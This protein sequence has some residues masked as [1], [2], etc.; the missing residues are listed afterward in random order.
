M[1]PKSLIL[2]ALALGCGLV[3]S[4]GISQVMDRRADG[5]Q[6]VVETVPIFVAKA[7]IKEMTLLT[8]QNVEQEQWPKA[9]VPA[10]ALLKHE[11]WEGQ[12]P[13]V[14]IYKGEPIIK[15]KI[16]DKNARA[17]SNIPNGFRTVAISVD[18]VSNLGG[19]LKPHDKVDVLAYFSRN[20][21]N[22]I[23]ETAVR[24]ILR[25]VEVFAVDSQYKR[26]D[27]G[28]EVTAAKVVSL[29]V[30]PDQ[31]EKITLA[32]ETGKIRL[33]LRNNDDDTNVESSGE[34]RFSDLGKNED[35]S[36]TPDQP[37]KSTASDAI[38][39]ILEVLSTP[40]KAE[41]P[42]PEKV[43]VQPP[44]PDKKDTFTMILMEGKDMKEVEFNL[45][46]GGLPIIRGAD[47][48]GASSL[49][50]PIVSPDVGH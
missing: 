7:D 25:K 3:A 24:T 49:P 34:S 9:K 4:I 6:A 26:G 33:I 17:D 23:N 38:K 47:S 50:A 5:G 10:G 44:A 31:A 45:A 12:R 32:A 14:T 37:S 30:T 16:A 22:G 19:I 35:A 43:A 39:N 18:G 13:Q 42:A 29:V 46:G 40:K 36:S 1:R 8:D 15:A 27:N 41:E 48:K 2:L 20:P 11:D 21:Q 28:D